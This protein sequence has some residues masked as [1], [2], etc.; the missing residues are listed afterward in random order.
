L[1]HLNPLPQRIEDA[2]HILDNRMKNNRT[3][4][5]KDR[6]SPLTYDEYTKACEVLN[7]AGFTTKL[8]AFTPERL[9]NYA[10]QLVAKQRDQGAQGGKKKSRKYRKSSKSRKNRKTRSRK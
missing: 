9:A 1:S 4:E 3:K 2:K 7:N 8:K 10:M 6:N 5:S